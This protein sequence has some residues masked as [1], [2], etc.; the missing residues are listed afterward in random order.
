MITM[1][2]TPVLKPTGRARGFTLVELLIATALS[3]VLLAAVLTSFLMLG[4]SGTNLS[5]YSEMES[6]ARVSLERFAQDVRQ[7]G[8]IVWNSDT[9]VTLSFNGLPDVTYGLGGTGNTQFIRTVNS[10]PIESSVL[11]SNVL[12]A[13]FKMSAYTVTGY[14]LPVSTATERL[15][16]NRDTKQL[17]LQLN[18]FRKSVTVNRATNTVLSA[19]FIL[20][21]KRVT[22]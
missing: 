4:R 16:A 2:P 22:S 10:T 11:I 6:Q 18:S 5:N 12:P 14:A 8:N 13:T 1:S 7:A 9:N 21:N 3:S 15:A 17:Q 20:R 19:R